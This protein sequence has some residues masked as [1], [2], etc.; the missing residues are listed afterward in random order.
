MYIFIDMETLGER[1][2]YAHKK[3]GH[4]QDSLAKT[5][6]V[7]RDMTFNLVKNKIEPQVIVSMSFDRH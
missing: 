6:D 5:I 2:N 1:L 7:S 4:T 3:S